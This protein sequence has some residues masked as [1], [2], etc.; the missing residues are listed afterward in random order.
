MRQLVHTHTHT[1]TQ[2]AHSNAKPQDEDFAEPEEEEEVQHVAF[3]LSSFWLVAYHML[4]HTITFISA[5]FARH[6][7]TLSD[8][9]FDTQMSH[10]VRACGWLT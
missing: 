10:T 1:Y 6:Y 2:L 3:A 5:H 7:R 4:Q 9:C 8:E